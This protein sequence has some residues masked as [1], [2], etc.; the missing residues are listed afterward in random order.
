MIGRNLPGMRRTAQTVI[1]M[2]GGISTGDGWR[3]ALPI[4]GMMSPAPFAATMRA[5]ADLEQRMRAAGFSFGD[6]LYAAV[7]DLRFS[8]RL[9]P[10]AARCHRCKVRRDRG[11]CVFYLNERS[12]YFCD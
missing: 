8:P 4:A 3:F 12:W 1:E 9:A 2:G 7:P 11:A 6:I 5:Q 10:H